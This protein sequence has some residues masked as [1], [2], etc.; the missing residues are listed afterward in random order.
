MTEEG[1]TLLNYTNDILQL[2][3]E[4]K[5]A[6]N[7]NKWRES[8]KIGATQTI[9]AVKIP[10]LLS[11][12]LKEYSNIDVKIK[13]NN[14]S[15]LAEMLFYGEVDGIFVNNGYRLTEYETIFSYFEEIVLISP[16]LH[17]IN[18]KSNQILIV[19]SDEN[20]IYRKQLLNFF[21]ER[22]FN[23]STI[24]E[25]DS[26]ESIIQAVHDGLGISII[27]KDIAIT[28][29]DTQE[30]EFTELP[31]KIK[32]DFIIKNRKQQTPGLRKFIRFLQMS[33]L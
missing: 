13:T 28:R 18:M 1:N 14:N 3:D 31:K 33:N 5:T 25:F 7:P 11:S 21:N 22:N 19:N 4:A 26:L 9:S 12:F 30:I 10:H 8:L 2:L 27:P 24:I 6:V 17:S 29:K 15:K 20:C 16:L 23:R 32:V